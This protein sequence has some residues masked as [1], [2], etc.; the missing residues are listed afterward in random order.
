MSSDGTIPLNT[1]MMNRLLPLATIIALLPIITCS[2]TAVPPLCVD[3]LFYNMNGESYIIETNFP[4]STEDIR[5]THRLMEPYKAALL[6]FG[7]VPNIESYSAFCSYIYNEYPDASIT[8]FHYDPDTGEEGKRL[9]TCHLSDLGEIA[10]IKAAYNDHYWKN[11]RRS[12]IYI[13]W[14][15]V[16]NPE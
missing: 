16:L 5:P 15:N 1:Y 4:S 12:V 11:E 7:L 6:F 8:I 3:V 10:K 13:E 9:L 2:C 14:S